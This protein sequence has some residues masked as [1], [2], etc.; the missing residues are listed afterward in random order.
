MILGTTFVFFFF[1][2]F[3]P[4]DFDIFYFNAA[5]PWVPLRAPEKA[6]HENGTFTM[7]WRINCG[8]GSTL[9]ETP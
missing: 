8:N 1:F 7:N 9:L 5:Q 3:F 4:Q 6:A 2:Y